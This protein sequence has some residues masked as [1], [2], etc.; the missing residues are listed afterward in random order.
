MSQ[1]PLDYKTYTAVVERADLR[2]HIRGLP[3]RE[4]ALRSLVEEEPHHPEYAAAHARYAK[5]QPPQARTALT[6]QAPGPHVP[7][8][9]APPAASPVPP[10]PP[11]TSP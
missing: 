2:K 1:T 7:P 6:K 8:A 9:V 11:Q 4:A 10:P 3:T 5:A